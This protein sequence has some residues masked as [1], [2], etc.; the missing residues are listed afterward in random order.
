MPT[1]FADKLEVKEQPNV[2]RK[3]LKVHQ[4]ELAE[5]IQGYFDAGTMRDVEETIVEI[6]EDFK[7][8]DSEHTFTQSVYMGLVKNCA[9]LQAMISGSLHFQLNRRHEIED[10]LTA[11]EARPTMTYMGVWAADR[12]Y[13]RGNVVTYDGSSWVANETSMGEIPG[14]G[15]AFTLAVKRGR[16]G[17]ER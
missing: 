1:F 15:S 13:L 11:L 3:G 6:V 2:A 12:E 10:R 9:V 14:K 17:R 5:L 16:D 7:E 4:D 8:C